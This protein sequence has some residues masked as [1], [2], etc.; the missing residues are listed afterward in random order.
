MPVVDFTH[1]NVHWRGFIDFQVNVSSLPKGMVQQKENL[2]GIM[3]AHCTWLKRLQFSS[4]ISQTSAI[5]PY[6]GSS[7]RQW[8]CPVHNFV[9]KLTLLPVS[10]YVLNSNSVTMFSISCCL[11]NPKLG[12]HLSNLHSLEQIRPWELPSRNNVLSSCI[13]WLEKSFIEQH[14]KTQEYIFI[15]KYTYTKRG[16]KLGPIV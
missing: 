5:S 3:L 12:N 1:L 15:S 8:S 7:K 11:G 13:Q 10:T 16:S 4:L 6:S 9:V 14:H 2:L